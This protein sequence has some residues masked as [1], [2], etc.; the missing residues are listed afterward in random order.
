MQRNLK[1]ESTQESSFAVDTVEVNILHTL[2]I[3]MNVMVIL[4]F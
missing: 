3:D 1:L 2:I 4:G